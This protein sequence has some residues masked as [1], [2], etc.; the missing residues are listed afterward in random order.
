M[1]KGI[2]INR[3]R[4]NSKKSVCRRNAPTIN[5]PPRPTQTLTRLVITRKVKASSY[6]SRRRILG[7]ADEVHLNAL[8]A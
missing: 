1:F 2:E 6:S 3:I 8:L 7:F 5:E 4:K